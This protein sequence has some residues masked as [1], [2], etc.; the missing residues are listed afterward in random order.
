LPSNFKKLDNSGELA[1]PNRQIISFAL[2]DNGEVLIVGYDGTIH[3][4]VAASDLSNSNEVVASFPKRLSVLLSTKR[5]TWSEQK[6][7]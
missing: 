5:Q 2:D 6:V 3:K 1:D 4:L 7:T